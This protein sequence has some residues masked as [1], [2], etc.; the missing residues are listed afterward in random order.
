MPGI[1]ERLSR[2][3]SLPSP[4]GIAV[5]II[6]MNEDDE[7]QI[8]ELARVISRDPAIAAKLLKTANSSSM[9]RPGQVGDIEDAIMVLGIRNVNLLALSF[10]LSA[11]A[12]PNPSRSFDYGR[13]WIESAVN[14]IAA[15]SIANAVA[16]RQRDEAFLCG[17]LCDFGQLLLA[18]MV[19]SEYAPV[20]EQERATHEPVHVIEASVLSCDHAEVGSDVLREWGLPALVC[21]SIGAHHDPTLVEGKDEDAERLAQVLQL[22]SACASLYVSG[23]VDFVDEILVLG[24]RYFGM[25]PNEVQGIIDQVREGVPELLEILDLKAVDQS[26]VAR[27]RDQASELLV[28]EGLQLNQRVSTISGTVERLTEQNEKL[29]R[30]ARTDPLTGLYNRRYMDEVL[31]RELGRASRSSVSV[32]LLIIDI[33]RFKQIN[34][35]HGHPAGDM[36]LRGLASLIESRL[37]EGQHAIRCGGDEFIVVA[38]D[39]NVEDLLERARLLRTTVEQ[40]SFEWE[41]H[42]IKAT[43]SI[44]GAIVS[45]PRAAGAEKA[46][47]SAADQEL[48]K[49]K[50][51]GRNRVFVTELMEEDL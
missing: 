25:G 14:T 51:K 50:S 7:L 20:I 17:L 42:D 28:E 30:R 2:T 36:V 29:E 40:T 21:D 5:E 23:S 47:L 9:G 1:V 48:Y 33:D 26:E 22:A 27:L 3:N 31:E 18:E 19:P 43:F 8:A 24:E 49:A 12:A 10:S 39:T 11:H 34:D 45:G 44:G 13:F 16:K 41:G 46:L 4:P 35:F 6:R 37:S 15:R 32:G 38:T